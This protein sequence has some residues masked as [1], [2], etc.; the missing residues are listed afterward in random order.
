VVLEER[1]TIVGG[2]STRIVSELVPAWLDAAVS[3]DAAS[4][5]S[6]KL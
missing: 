2:A 5:S 1:V 4:S 6:V 3:S